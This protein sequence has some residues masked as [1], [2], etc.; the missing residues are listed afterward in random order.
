MSFLEDRNAAMRLVTFKEQ[1]TV[2]RKAFDI[3]REMLAT[4]SSSAI[5]GK[6]AKEVIFAL[7]AELPLWISWVW[8][9]FV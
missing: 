1:R 9:K 2:V 5:I 4:H 6:N 8:E 7:C 3:S